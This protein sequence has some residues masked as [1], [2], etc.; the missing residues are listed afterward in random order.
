MEGLRV[1][2]RDGKRKTV[3][4]KEIIEGFTDLNKDKGR[5]REER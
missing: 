1:T 5:Q 2:G 4:G 3:N